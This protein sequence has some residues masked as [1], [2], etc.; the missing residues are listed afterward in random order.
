MINTDAFKT[1]LEK[2]LSDITIDLQELGIHNP[3]VKE[4]WIAVP[5]DVETQEADENVAADRA[6]DWLERT[7]TLSALEKRYNNIIKALNKIEAGSYGICEICNA[8]IEEDRLEANPTAR[9][10]KAHINDEQELTA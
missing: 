6:E 10:C 7:A 3:Q 4:D 1:Q 2:E 9:T 8:S 5:K